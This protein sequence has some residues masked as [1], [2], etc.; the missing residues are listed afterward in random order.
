MHAQPGRGRGIHAIL[1]HVMA[2]SVVFLFLFVPPLPADPATGPQTEYAE[3]V[4]TLSPFIER[5]VR[6]KELGALSIALVDDQKIVW[7]RGFGFQDSGKNAPA[8]A[9]AV[10]RVG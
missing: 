7:A 9:D 3:L 1:L 4:A 8:T 5:E 6:D 10:Y 2:W